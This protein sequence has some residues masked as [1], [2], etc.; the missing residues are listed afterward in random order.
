MDKLQELSR[1][2][3]RLSLRLGELH[4]DL[5]EEDKPSHDR[6]Y[7]IQNE[8]KSIKERYDEME[9]ETQAIVMPQKPQIIAQPSGADLKALPQFD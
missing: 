4:N 3:Q 7:E 1:E 8:T 9:Q 6:V 5:H 2:E